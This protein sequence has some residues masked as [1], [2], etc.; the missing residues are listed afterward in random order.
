[1]LGLT[2]P[3]LQKWAR[4]STAVFPKMFM[5]R[6]TLSQVPP[7]PED[8]GVTPPLPRIASPPRVATVYNKL[9]GG[10]GG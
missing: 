10:G 4:C 5:L 9:S 6:E 8:H 7:F 2:Q 3:Q 1:M